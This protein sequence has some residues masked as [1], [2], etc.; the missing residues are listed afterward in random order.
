MV[1]IISLAHNSIGL[2]H[3][4]IT[5]I[6]SIYI[7][8]GYFGGPINVSL[9]PT[10]NFML[11]I[12]MMVSIVY[13][14]VST[15]LIVFFDPKNKKSNQLIFHHIGAY[16]GL[17]FAVHSQRYMPFYGMWYIMEISSIFLCYRHLSRDLNILRNKSLMFD[18]MFVIA[19]ILSRFIVPI[20]VYIQL[21]TTPNYTDHVYLINIII[22]T[23]SIL[24]NF[25]WLREIYGLIKHKFM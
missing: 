1:D 13:F 22:S 6:V 20:Y 25:V 4:L 23:I 24:L 17:W 2:I 16:I 19:Y 3:S 8:I 10:S 5:S 9:D 7:I 12:A 21:I 15:L 14:F 18:L 11:L